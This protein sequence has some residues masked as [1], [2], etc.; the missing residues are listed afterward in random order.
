MAAIDDNLRFETLVASIS[1]D[2]IHARPDNIDTLIQSAVRRIAEALGGN[3]VL[4]GQTDDQTEELVARAQYRT[5]DPPF[6][7]KLSINELNPALL[8]TLAAGEVSDVADVDALPESATTDREYF[9][10][11]GLRSYMAVPVVIDGALK[12]MLAIGSVG[13]KR[14]WPKEAVPRMRVLAEVLAIALLRCEAEHVV[15]ANEKVFRAFV[16][17][18]PVPIMLAPGPDRTPLYFN[19][20]FTRLFGYTRQD[21]PTPS[22]WWPR[23]YPQLEYRAQRIA[24]WDR[25]VAVGQESG[26]TQ[27][28]E[29]AEIRRKDGTLCYADIRLALIEGYKLIFFSDLTARR[30][31]E[32]E[33]RLTQYAVDHNPAMI[34]RIECDG[35]FVYAN[36]AACR[37][38]QWSPAEVAGHW[39]WDVSATLDKQGWTGHSAGIRERG[40]TTLES[41]YRRKDGTTFP[42]EIYIYP[43]RFD[44][45]DCFF[46]FALDITARRA[47]QE[48]AFASMKRLKTLASGLSRGEEQQRRDLARLLHDDIGQDLFAVTTQLLALK[49]RVGSESQT[50]GNVLNLLDEI[51]RHTRELTFEL[52][53]PELSQVGLSAALKRLIASFQ[54]R[55]GLPVTL[56]GS[57]IGPADL[58][59]R[60]L[61]FH[62][63]RELLFNVVKHAHATQAAVRYREIDGRMHID[64]SDNGTGY[65]DYQTAT[66]KPG[67]GLFYLRE[68]VELLGGSLSIECPQQGC[69][70]SFEL[71]L[72]GLSGE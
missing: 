4:F 52:C 16:E 48:E 36:D 44:G 62:A 9:R 56:E 28:A 70:V 2:L 21:V 25:L 71:P 31:I 47:A 23:A 54:E 51:T 55:Y 29:E 24:G 43:I 50:I 18:A 5:T 40:G 1:S 20:A 59:V 7:E 10:R 17:Q 45:G 60:G 27:D 41:V 6:P 35:R 53:P 58:D 72:E 26:L 61:A 49:N 13:E 65:N 39:I 63:V 68:R 42:V 46:C 57:G 34:F 37:K 66:K 32:K 11:I 67:F 30:E 3:R 22:A 69:R 33:L 12:F 64:V 15:Q 19:P 8:R 38:F 14:I